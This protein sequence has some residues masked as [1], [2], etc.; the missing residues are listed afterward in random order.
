MLISHGEGVSPQYRKELDHFQGAA[1]RLYLTAMKTMNTLQRHFQPGPARARAKKL[2]TLARTSEGGEHE[3]RQKK[4][5]QM[6]RRLDK[7]E[8]HDAR[9]KDR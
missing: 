2:E 4:L 6:A 5:E 8:R 9:K 7:Q 1:H 3:A